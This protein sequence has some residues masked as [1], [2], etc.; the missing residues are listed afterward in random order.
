[1]SKPT[2]YILSDLYHNQIPALQYV[3]AELRK[4]VNKDSQL[5]IKLQERVNELAES[6]ITN[7]KPSDGS[8]VSSCNCASEIES[9]KETLRQ[10]T[11]NNTSSSSCDCASELEAIRE[12]LRQ[13]TDN[14]PP[15]N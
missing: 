4:K 6:G 2:D 7:D 14:P 10:L 12:T 1:M 11:E 13:L 5:I 3:I 9:I 15:P 8:N